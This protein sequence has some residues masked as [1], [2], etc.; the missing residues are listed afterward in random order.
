MGSLSEWFVA[1]FHYNKLEKISKNIELTT[2]ATNQVILSPPTGKRLRLQVLLICAK[3][4][5]GEVKLFRSSDT[6]TI[7][8]LDISTSNKTNTSNELNM[9]LN[10]DETVKVTT[11]GRG[12]NWTFIGIGYNV[13]D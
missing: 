4:N 10:V 7:L 1:K 3:G 6:V 12:S 8:P 5:Q 13:E 11:T 2:D 9:L